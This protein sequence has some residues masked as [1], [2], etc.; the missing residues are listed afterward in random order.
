MPVQPSAKSLAEFRGAALAMKAVAREVRNDINRT[1]RK[2]LNVIWREAIW[3]RASQAGT[4][5]D[6]RVLAQGARAVPGNPAKVVAATSKRPLPGGGGLIP[7]EIGRGWEFGSPT[8][9]RESTYDRKTPS[10]T[11]SV[12]RHASRQMPRA[13][14]QGRVVYPAW[15]DTAPRMI[16]LWVQTIVYKASQALENK[17]R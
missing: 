8:P 9:E 5:L 12:T 7:D 10:G 15:S 16:S 6:S 1:L 11:T 4:K 2:E 14:K 3:D 17:G 13:T